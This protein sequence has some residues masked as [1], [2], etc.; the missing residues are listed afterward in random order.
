MTQPPYGYGPPPGPQSH[1]YQPAPGYP[2]P[3]GYQPAPGYQ[4]PPGPQPGYG[5]PPGYPPAYGAPNA[6]P[7]GPP[8]PYQRP[9]YPPRPYP[10]RRRSSGAGL[11]A[12]L[13]VLTVIVAVVGLFVASAISADNE[14]NRHRPSAYTP[15]TPSYTYTPPTSATTSSPSPTSRTASQSTT[16][17]AAPTTTKPAGPQPVAKLGE[18]PLFSD[19][20]SGLINIDCDYPAWA[21]TTAAATRFFQ[22]AADCLDKKWR[23]TLQ[24]ANLPFSS[25]GL[26]VPARASDATSPCTTAS[27]SFAAFYC[28]TNHTIYMPLDKI[29]VEKYGDDVVI[30]LSVFAH[31]YGHHVQALSGIS[32]RMNT[33][34]NEAGTRTA[35]GLELSRRFELEADC[36]SGMY[37]GTSTY[38]GVFT[39][40]QM[41][42]ATQDQV[43]RGDR[44]GDARDHGTGQ[45]Q[46]NWFTQGHKYDRTFQCNTWKA[47][48]D[49]VS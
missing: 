47:P 43:G 8:M 7:Y 25:P 5:L 13:G 18:N 24:G 33:E 21:A 48:S 1:G 3:P 2:P 41:T 20:N 11:S 49:E 42:R 22:A 28:S 19:D 44:Q 34:R 40:A 14:K 36:F 17:A 6:A 26:S 29:Q 23:P 37:V 32:Q 45:N 12:L 15:P 30:Y 27:S 46:A 9:G 31:E 10:P 35:L 38:D 4:P 16:G 39:V